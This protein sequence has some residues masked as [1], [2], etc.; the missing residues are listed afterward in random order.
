M[1]AGVFVSI[2]PT[3][4]PPWLQ[5]QIGKLQQMQSSLQSVMTQ[6]QHIESERIETDR[7]L[8]ELQ[9]AGD[10]DD[11]F[12]HAGSILIK[13]TKAAL[14]LELKEKKELA[15][16]RKTVLEKQE[17]RLREGLK[18]QEEKVTKMITDQSKGGL[19]APPPPPQSPS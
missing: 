19:S 14:I 4:I 13:S 11:V 5:E 7:A 10:N 3:N 12:K 2:D 16:T 17:T 8:E 6:K 15:E 1:N 9:K 18:E